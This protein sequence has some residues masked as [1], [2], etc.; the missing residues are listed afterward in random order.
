MDLSQTCDEVGTVSD[1]SSKG[2]SGHLQ[3]IKT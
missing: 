1:Q 2:V 3:L